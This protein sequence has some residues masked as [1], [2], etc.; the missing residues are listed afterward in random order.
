MT[1]LLRAKYLPNATAWSTVYGHKISLCF[2]FGLFTPGT[3]PYRLDSFLS[4][5]QH[6]VYITSPTSRFI[7]STLL[8]KAG[9]KRMRNSDGR[10]ELCVWR[11]PWK[12]TLTGTRY[13]CTTK[14]LKANRLDYATKTVQRLIVATF[15]SNFY[16]EVERDREQRPPYSQSDKEPL[17]LPPRRA[18]GRHRPMPPP[19]TLSF[20]AEQNLS[21]LQA[22]QEVARRRLHE[23]SLLFFRNHADCPFLLRRLKTLLG[24]LQ[25]QV[26]YVAIDVVPV[27]RSILFLSLYSEQCS[28][29]VD[30]QLCCCS[31]R[32]DDSSSGRPI[33]CACFSLVHQR[34]CTV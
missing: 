25:Y 32:L 16:R 11:L 21:S 4:A 27:H 29:V 14:T 33:L 22:D 8:D 13:L 34:G 2:R 31:S 3:N 28:P 17:C 5:H 24:M 7:G 19:V 9:K 18:S 30:D 23:E 20:Q 6:I 26:G 12:G 15:R 10:V 1:S